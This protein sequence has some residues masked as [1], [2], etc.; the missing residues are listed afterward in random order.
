MPVIVQDGLILQL[1]LIGV[2]PYDVVPRVLLER[3]PTMHDTAA[4]RVRSGQA[5]K[6]E[7][8]V[9]K[10]QLFDLRQRVCAVRSRDADAAVT[11][12]R[13]GVGRAQSREA[14]TVDTAPSADRVV[15]RSA[16]KKIVT[17]RAADVV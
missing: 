12:V 2:V 16:D 11:Q 10:D 14:R 1:V 5:I 15:A 6:N 7:A 9:A 3:V 17:I 4:V 8:L 13:Q